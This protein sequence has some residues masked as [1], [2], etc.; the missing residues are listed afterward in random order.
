MTPTDAFSA[1]IE[2]CSRH[3]YA[4]SAA[5]QGGTP[6]STQ[7][8]HALSQ[9]VRTAFEDFMSAC[10]YEGDLEGVEDATEPPQ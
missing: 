7:A 8:E 3:L 4:S 5:Q 1:L 2:A 6:T 10:A 9:R